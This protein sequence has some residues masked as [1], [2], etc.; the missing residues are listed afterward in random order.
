M[1]AVLIGPTT[2]PTTTTTRVYLNATFL[3][4]IKYNT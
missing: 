3:R 4:I 1:A 2:K